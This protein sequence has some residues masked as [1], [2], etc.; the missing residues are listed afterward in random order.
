VKAPN[1]PSLNLMPAARVAQAH[2][3][4]RTR[5]WAAGLMV[6]TCAGAALWT[7]FATSGDRLASVQADVVTTAAQIESVRLEFKTVQA[8]LLFAQREAEARHEVQHHPDMSVLLRQLA[9]A[10][11]PNITFEKLELKP[12]PAPAGI[13]TEPD[14][15]APWGYTLAVMGIAG[16]QGEVPRFALALQRLKLF[17]A[18]S[19]QSIKAREAPIIEKEDGTKIVSPLLFNF[20]IVS[21]LSDAGA[22]I[23]PEAT[24]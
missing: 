24:R 20:E 6:Y 10:A 11:G 5:S 16:S 19:V 8:K 3:K 2:R 12:L 17:E 9:E 18:V 21:T 14:L 15:A 1:V 22:A 13:V 4:R 23:A 7:Y